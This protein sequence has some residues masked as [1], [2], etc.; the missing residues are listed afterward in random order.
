VHDMDSLPY[1]D[2]TDFF[3][4][5]AKLPAVHRPHPPVPLFETARGCWGGAKHHCKI[6]GLNSQTTSFPTNSPGR[7]YDELTW[8]V[9]CHGTDVVSVDNILD[10]VY[11]KEL[12]LWI[13]A[14][15]RRIVMHFETKSNLR[16]D[17][18]EMLARAGLRK[19]QPGIETLDSDILR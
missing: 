2:F 8:I 9:D 4:Q 14:G 19:I 6:F 16:R 7:A 10:M 1:P 17:Q 3:D 5:H 12:L 15:D 11:F 18:V 13:A